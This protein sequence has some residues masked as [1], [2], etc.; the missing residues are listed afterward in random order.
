MHHQLLQS[1]RSSATRR[2]PSH[3]KTLHAYIHKIGLDQYGALPNTLI[4]MYAKCGLIKDALQLFDQMPHRDQVS[5]ASILTAYNQSNLSSCA[6]AVFAASF[7]R[8]CLQP[9][10]FIF[11][12]LL[13]SCAALNALQI[14]HQVHAQFLLSPYSSDDVVKSSLVDMYA[15]CGLV[16][17]ARAVFDTI[18]SKNSISLTAMISGYARSGRKSEAI[19]LL[20]GMKE[21][22]LFSWTALISGLIQSGHWVSA[23]HLFIV[24][25]KEGIKIIDPFILS[26]VIG[27]SANHAALELAKVRNL[28][29]A[30]DV[31]KEPAYSCVHLGKESQVKSPVNCHRL[32]C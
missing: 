29:A 9:D 30:M 22:N 32:L 18:S 28:M 21:A 10:H 26:S 25:R 31:K 17:V 15:K 20:R 24:M 23:F 13:N 27:A 1:L 11:A 6:L 14:G 8:D 4:S 7:S 5:W 19:E 2:R 12:S 16:D 3:G